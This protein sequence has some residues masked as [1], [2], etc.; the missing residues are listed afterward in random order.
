MS[1]TKDQRCCR[2][3]FMKNTALAGIGAFVMTGFV[4]KAFSEGT[5]EK[6]NPEKSENES[7]ILNR[8]TNPPVQIPDVRIRMSHLD[9]FLAG[10]SSS[11]VVEISL[12]DVLKFHGYCAAGV[13]LAFREAQEAFRLLYGDKLPIRQGIKVQTAYHC[14]QAGVLAYIT[15]ARTDFGALV[16]RGDLVLI[17]EE[18]KKVVFT[19]KKTEKS[20]TLLPQVDPHSMFVPLFRK[21]RQD[22]SIASQVRKLLNDTVQDYISC[23]PEKLFK[24]H[25]G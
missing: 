7:K 2:R 21:V 5:K 25:H 17:P 6:S 1:D 13:T 4:P 22:N 19:D 20:V 14:C 15:G 10:V 18:M 11:E 24:I 9:A 23:P 12:A 16:S 8:N 3:D